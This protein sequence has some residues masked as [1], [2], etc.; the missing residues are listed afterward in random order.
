MVPKQLC[1]I[2]FKLL[3]FFDVRFDFQNNVVKD[4][5]NTKYQKSTQHFFS[6]VDTELAF[7]SCSDFL[8]LTLSSSQDYFQMSFRAFNLFGQPSTQIAFSCH[9]PSCLTS[10]QLDCSADL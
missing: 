7:R 5:N 1:P 4:K 8:P 3:E 6:R 2:L 9:V 10:F